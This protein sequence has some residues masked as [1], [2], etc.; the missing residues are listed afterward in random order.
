MAGREIACTAVTGG[1][2]TVIEDVSPEMVEEAMAYVLETLQKAV[3]RGEMTQDQMD[4]AIAR[5]STARTVEDACR[6]A[7]ML[8]EAGP[9]ELESKLEIF[10]LFDRFA[11]PGAILACTSSSVSITDLADITF[12]GENCVGMHFAGGTA[13]PDSV[14]ITRGQETSDATVAACAE[15]ARRMGKEVKIATERANR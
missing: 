10:T 2:R 11:K 4:A 1:Y 15:V 7:D 5:L 8:I 6:Q 13:R 14:K 3:A 12:R 9:E